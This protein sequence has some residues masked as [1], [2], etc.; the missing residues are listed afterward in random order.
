MCSTPPATT[1][2]AA[3]IAISPAPAVTAVSA[4]GAHAVDRE[5][6]H[7]LRDPGQQADVA[8]ERQALVADLGRRGQDDVADPLGRNLRVAA[9]KLAD[10]L[11]GHVVGARP[12]EDALRP[13]AA[14]GRAHAVDV[15]DLRSAP[16]PPRR[17]YSADAGGLGRLTS[18]AR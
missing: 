18:P 1:T 14:E 15:D 11:H 13:R 2:S 8:P 16:G 12:P 10:D 17:A 5:A 6:G 9:Q 3:P 7:G 4:P